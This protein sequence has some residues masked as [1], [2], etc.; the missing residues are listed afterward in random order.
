[1]IGGKFVDDLKICEN[2]I[3]PDRGY[4][5]CVVESENEKY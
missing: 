4:E 5:I 1:L 2:G 3:C